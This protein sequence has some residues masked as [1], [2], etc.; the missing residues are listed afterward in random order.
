MLGKNG[1]NSSIISYSDHVVFPHS[2]KLNAH[3]VLVSVVAIESIN[4]LLKKMTLIINL[5]VTDY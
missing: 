3:A 5:R 4:L 1:E 2:V